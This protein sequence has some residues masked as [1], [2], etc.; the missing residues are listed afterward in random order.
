MCFPVIKYA[1]DVIVFTTT[2]H[3]TILTSNKNLTLMHLLYCTITFKTK[4]V[5][6]YTV[7]ESVYASIA[8]HSKIFNISIGL[9]VA[10]LTYPDQEG[11][12]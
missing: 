12:L 1:Y 2:I 10:T 9:S 8:L 11:G 3:D 7:E 6:L 4:N 5:Q